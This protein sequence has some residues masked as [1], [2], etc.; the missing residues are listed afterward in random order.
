MGHDQGVGSIAST[1]VTVRDGPPQHEQ[2]ATEN[3][4][5]VDH[6]PT[7][8]PGISGAEQRVLR[9]E[10]DCG[11]GATSSDAMRSNCEHHVEQQPYAPPYHRAAQEP[12][13]RCQFVGRKFVVTYYGKFSPTKQTT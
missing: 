12:A 4:S 11:S 1:G 2:L 3:E 5:N 10:I 8:V 6:D 13:R 9:G 7:P